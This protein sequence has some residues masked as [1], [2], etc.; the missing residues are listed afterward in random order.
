[1][2]KD[3]LQNIEGSCKIESI[4]AGVNYRFSILTPRLVRLEYAA[5][6]VFE[7]RP[8]QTV[9]NRNFETPYFTVYETEKQLEIDTD[10]LSI[11]YDKKKFS[12]GGLSVKVRSES[13][14]I[15]STWHFSEAVDE[16]LWGT[17][18]TLDQADGEISLEPGLQSRLGGFGVLDDSESLVLLESGWVEPRKEGVEDIYFFGYGYEYKQC[19]R[20]FFHLSGKTPLLPRYAL[21]NWWSRFYA[22]SDSEYNDLMDAF[23][24]EEVPLSVAVIDMDWHIREVNPKY[25]KG[26]TGYTW[27]RK[28]FPEPKEFMSGL[29]K[30]DLKVTLNLHPA[31]GVQPHEEMYEEMARALGRNPDR[32]QPI[33]FDFSDP[34]FIEAYFK[35][36]HHPQEKDG[37]DFWWVD[38]QQGSTSKIPNAD[39]IWMLNHFHSLDHARDGKRPMIL[40]RYAGPG[41]HRYPLGFSG[42]SVI[43]WASLNF[44]PYF[45]A[46]ASNIGYGWWSHDIGGHAGGSKD[47]ELLVRWLQFGVFS[48]I[49]RLHSTSNAFNGKEPWK[50]SEP[51]HR[52]MTQFLQ[53]RHKLVPYLYTMNWRCHE[54]GEMLVQPMYYDDPREED[55]YGVPN[56]YKFGSELIVYPITSPMDSSLRLGCVT[57]WLPEGTY[58]DLF[59][60]LRY[61]GGRLLNV[62]RSMDEIP[63]FAKAGAIVPMTG[64]EEAKENGV[65]LPEQMEIKVFA[66]ANG[67]FEL[68]EDDGESTAYTEGGFT[69]TDF[70]FLWN[71]GKGSSFSIQRSGEKIDAMPE[72]R[73]FTIAITGITDTDHIAVRV[74]DTI[75]PYSKAYDAKHKAVIIELPLCNSDSQ[76]IISFKDELV[77]ADNNLHKE[78]FERLSKMQIGYELKERIYNSVSRASHAGIAIT[79]LQAMDIPKGLLGVISEILFAQ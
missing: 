73:Q 19:L 62:Y 48:P 7:D 78:I 36:L 57:A 43:S 40:S 29:H 3:K 66:G 32:E 75:V 37:V 58:F 64:E 4:I 2:K 41:S 63:V 45:T 67:Q 72:K 25:G 50:Y 5:D 33:H 26:W 12:I 79:E 20:D 8:T 70:N 56:Q 28:L 49:M 53:F 39:P 15:Y 77:L 1:M 44:Q 69:I 54:Y 74:D 71:D 13:R 34:S 30:R 17:T 6:G 38:W 16:G 68:Y 76:M 18:R 21:G 24:A 35:H 51:A 23:T 42:D 10:W 46:T 11:S 31:E 55:A 60:G 22:Y 61:R 27:N 59:T 65:K 52:I 47:D 14:G 9:I